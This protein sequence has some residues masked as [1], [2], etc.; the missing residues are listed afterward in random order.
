MKGH[1]EGIRK[2]KDKFPK[3]H[4]AINA[5]KDTGLSRRNFMGGVAAATA[6]FTIVPRHVLGG[7]DH[8]PPSEKLNIAGIGVGGKVLTKPV[9][10]PRG[11]LFVN[12]KSKWGQI[13]IE[14][15][16]SKGGVIDGMKSI[17]ISGDGVRL[18]V[19]WPEGSSWN[20]IAAKPLQ[21]CF[22]LNNAP[23][24]IHGRLSDMTCYVLAS[25]CTPASESIRPSL[26]ATA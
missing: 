11:E 18:P 12:A 26:Y 5:G 9:V 15:L 25:S 17:P 13:V 4:Q 20:K 21:L 24:Y 10:L 23:F 16:D 2:Q 19:R 3:V 8:K 22:T 1:K 6:A 14:V 7:P